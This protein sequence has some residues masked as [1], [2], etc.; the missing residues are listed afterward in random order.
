MGS[1]SLPSEIKVNPNMSNEEQIAIYL[2]AIK[3][4]PQHEATCLLMIY[5]PYCWAG[6]K[7]EAANC[8]KRVVDM[9]EGKLNHTEEEI[10]YLTFAYHLQA[11]DCHE[12]GDFKKA[13]FLREKIIVLEP[14]EWEGFKN[15]GDDYVSMKDYDNAI[16]VYDM[17]HAIKHKYKEDSEDIKGY[18][19][20]SMAELYEKKKDYATA[21]TYWEKQ[22]ALVDVTFFNA[23]DIHKK[24]AECYKHIDKSVKYDEHGKSIE[25]LNE[26][27]NKETDTSNLVRHYRKLASE[28]TEAKQGANANGCYRKA[29]E[30]L[31]EKIKDPKMSYNHL[32]YEGDIAEIYS[33]MGNKAKAIEL[34]EEIAPKIKDNQ[35]TF[36]YYKLGELYASLNNFPKAIENYR[37]MLE[38]NNR[39]HA[40]LEQLCAIYLHLKKWD[41]LQPYCEQLIEMWPDSSPRAYTTLALCFDEKDNYQKIIDLIENAIEVNHDEDE[42]L[43]GQCHCMLG[44]LYWKYHGNGEKAYEHYKKMMSYEPTEELKQQAGMYLVLMMFKPEGMAWADKFYKEF[45]V[46]KEVEAN[47]PILTQEEIKALPYHHSK[48]PEDIVETSQLTYE[49]KMAFAKELQTNPKYKEYFKQYEPYSVK[50]FIMNYVNHKMSLLSSAKY[51][52][53]PDMDSHEYWRRHHTEKVF[54]MILQKKMFN[55]QILWRANKADLPG[56]EI[57]YDFH[58]WEHKLINCKFLEEVTQQ[59]V[60]LMKEFLVDTS[61][62]NKE[63][64]YF[65]AWQ[66]YNENMAETEDGEREY[67]PLWYRFYDDRMNTGALLSLPNIKGEKEEEYKQIYYSWKRE[68]P[69]V[70]H[71][72]G[73]PYKMPKHLSRIWS[74]ESEYNKFMETYENDYFLFLNQKNLESKKY[75]D[76]TFTE[77]EDEFDSALS[78]LKWAD[79]VVPIEANESWHEAVIIAAAKYE[80]Q[81]TAD[82]LDDIYEEYLRNRELFGDMDITITNFLHSKNSVDAHNSLRKTIGDMILKGRELRG[83]PQDFN[84]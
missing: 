57:C 31:E 67:M 71:K 62:P 28:Y 46:K 4:Y 15:L 80:N 59:E 68:Q 58:G 47:R 35:V 76:E 21:I 16:R 55:L 53:N 69:P 54:D 34:F 63:K 29:I 23:A 38:I 25:W 14:L 70:K 13:A 84:Y 41:I 44:T 39:D 65:H 24:I 64:W 22:L 61:M 50:E 74:H 17:M 12:M 51:Y 43:S 10:N 79:E 81:R 82:H 11:C 77:N 18:Y 7:K 3:K 2:D 60:D 40:A 42:V 1:I 27:I 37:K 32:H 33:E 56:V 78:T 72:K 30:I 26:Q 45:P 36:T 52:A 20:E 49:T 6:K 66:D 73:K 83:E 8:L 19:F 5:M 48:V 9:F 75:L